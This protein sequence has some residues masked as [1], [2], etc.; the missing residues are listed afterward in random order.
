MDAIN[1][2]VNVLPSPAV[3]DT[4]GNISCQEAAKERGNGSRQ[5]WRKVSNV[6]NTESTSVLILW[7]FYLL[8]WSG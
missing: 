6:P 2:A 5:T 8:F 1:C 4:G 7:W 3:Q